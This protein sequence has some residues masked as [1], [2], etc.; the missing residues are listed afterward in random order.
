MKK[1]KKINC[2]YNNG[3]YHGGA[4]LID[5]ANTPGC[6]DFTIGH[7]EAPT[8]P[9]ILQKRPGM[10][11]RLAYRPI[12]GGG[13]K[14]IALSQWDDSLGQRVGIVV[15]PQGFIP[16]EKFSDGQSKAIIQGL[17]Y[18]RKSFIPSDSDKKYTLEEEF[19]KAY[20]AD[21][22]LSSLYTFTPVDDTY[23]LIRATYSPAGELQSEEVFN[24]DSYRIDK[25]NHYNISHGLDA[26]GYPVPRY[27]TCVRPCY[28]ILDGEVHWDTGFDKEDNTLSK[29]IG[30]GLNGTKC[31]VEYDAELFQLAADAWNYKA[32]EGDTLQ[33]HLPSFGD[34]VIM[35]QMY[36]LSF[37]DLYMGDPDFYVDVDSIGYWISVDL[38]KA[39][40][41][42]GW[43]DL[44]GFEEDN[45]NKREDFTRPVQHATITPKPINSYVGTDYNL[46][47]MS[48]FTDLTFTSPITYYDFSSGE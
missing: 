30:T 29:D 32:Y 8:Y 1:L 33:W 43:V 10:I 47:I 24:F 23:T 25:F 3:D 4:Q 34:V 13:L 22:V 39:L 27:N 36:D 21:P 45:H 14:Q 12:G 20:S 18:S 40:Y 35:D 44:S 46:T 19:Q 26:D 28:K 42:K 9:F 5:H 15:V 38:W 17:K 37:S 16:G 11:H 31:L 48:Y 2:V 41:Q 6:L 7:P